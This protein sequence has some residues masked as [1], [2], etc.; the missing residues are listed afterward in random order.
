MQT[1]RPENGRTVEPPDSHA[2][3]M[4][5]ERFPEVNFYHR[6]EIPY[7]AASDHTF[8]DMNS[9]K[10]NNV[11]GASRRVDIVDGQRTEYIR[12]SERGPGTPDLGL[13]L[14]NTQ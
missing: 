8:Q 11:K 4:S 9:T 12:V 2:R 1:S 13:E 7:M 3:Y 6:R 10:A 5:E 14:P